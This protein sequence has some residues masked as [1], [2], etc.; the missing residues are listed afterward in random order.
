MSPL[1]CF[2][3]RFALSRPTAYAP[4]CLTCCLT[5]GKAP[6]RVPRN[7][8]LQLVFHFQNNIVSTVRPF[9]IHPLFMH[10]ICANT[11]VDVVGLSRWARGCGRFIGLDYATR[12]RLRRYSSGLIA[13]KDIFIRSP[14]YQRRKSSSSHMN[15]SKETPSQDLV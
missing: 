2:H 1:S 3:S 11:S 12:P 6:S 8:A 14:L 13:P 10:S 9:A 15:S 4:C 5:H 7:L